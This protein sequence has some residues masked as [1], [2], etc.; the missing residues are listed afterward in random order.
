MDEHFVSLLLVAA[1]ALAAPLLFAALGEMVSEIAGVI[2]I[3]LK[4]MMLN[5]TFCDT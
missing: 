1:I 4:N 3:E 2:N 5:K